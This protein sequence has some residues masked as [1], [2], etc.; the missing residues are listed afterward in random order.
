MTPLT[1]ENAFKKFKS[2]YPETDITL[3]GFR[4][5]A[6]ENRIGSVLFGVKKVIDY[7]TIEQYIFDSLTKIA[8]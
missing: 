7:D 2:K 3:T 6:D 1:V 5:I 8:V 4:T